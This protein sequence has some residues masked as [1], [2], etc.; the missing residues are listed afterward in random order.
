M[1]VVGLGDGSVVR[2]ALGL[3]GLVLGGVLGVVLVGSL[4]FSTF[5]F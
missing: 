4:V 5:S 1:W 3:S 2:R